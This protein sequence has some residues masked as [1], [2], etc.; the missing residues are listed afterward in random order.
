[1]AIRVERCD[2]TLPIVLA[3]T[4][5][6]NTVALHEGVLGVY[7]KGGV[8]NDKVPFLI[9]GRVSGVKKKAGTG[10][11]WTAGKRLYWDNTTEKQCQTNATG[12]SALSNSLIAGAAAGATDTTGTIELI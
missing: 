3:G 10:L 2:Q 5:S 4:V 8:K 7:L 9:K 1:M 12:G 11:T 6:V